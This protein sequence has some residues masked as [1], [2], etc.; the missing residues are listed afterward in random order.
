MSID[1]SMDKENVMHF[2]YSG[3]LAIKNNKI[4]PFAVTWLDLE[5]I[6]LNEVS[7]RQIY[8]LTCMCNLKYDTSE[9]IYKTDSQT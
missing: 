9:H 4:K 8:S 2:I 7:Q 6:I 1:R 3:L 5:I